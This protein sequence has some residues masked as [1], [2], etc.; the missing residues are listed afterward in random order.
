M[1]HIL[2]TI[3]GTLLGGGT[4]AALI[5][6]ASSKGSNSVKREDVYADHTQELFKRLDKLTDERDELKDQVLEQSK[7]IDTLN[8]QIKQLRQDNDRLIEQVHK[9]AEKIN[10]LVKTDT[11]LKGVTK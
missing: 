10:G 7:T 1:M 9:L 3:V 2:S 8:N 5:N 11:E 4:V 6:Y